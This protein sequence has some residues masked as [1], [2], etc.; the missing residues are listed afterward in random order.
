MKRKKWSFI[1]F[2]ITERLKFQIKS[3]KQLM[4]DEMMMIIINLG[5]GTIIR[6]LKNHLKNYLPKSF[7]QF[8][9]QIASFFH[10]NYKISNKIK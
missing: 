7:K 9:H 2:Y 5:L 4:K 3:E 6:Q 8:I 10:I 1:L